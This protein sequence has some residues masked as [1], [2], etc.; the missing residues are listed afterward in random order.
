[1]LTQDDNELLTKTGP[2]TP[3]GELFRRFWLPAALSEELPSPDGPP[4]RVE[5]LG[6]KLVAFRD[7]DGNV[8]LIDAYCPH[9]GAPLFFGRNEECGLRCVY[10]GW[11][12]DVSGQCVDMPNAPEGQTFANKMAALTYPCVEAG[13]IVFTYMGP[14]VQQ[15]PFPEFEWRDLPEENRYVSKFKLECNYL[16]AMEG[17]FDPG[18]SPFLHTVIDG[19]WVPNP[20]YPG[21]RGPSQGNGIA[22]RPTPADEPFPRVV[23]PRR[24]TEEDRESWGTI[25]QSDS[26]SFFITSKQGADGKVSANVMPWMMPIFTTAGRSGPGTHSC[27]MRVPINDECMLFYRLRWSYEALPPLD[28]EEYKHGGFYYPA[29]I[30]GTWQTVD[31]VTNDY[32]IDRLTQKYFNYTGITP[33]PLQDIAMMEDQWG[34]I[35]DRTKEHLNTSDFRIIHIRR[36]LL[37]TVRNLN[38]GSEPSEPWHPEAYGYT[39]ET[40][41]KDSGSVDAVIEEAKA[42][43]KA[44][45]V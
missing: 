17:D 6:E 14:P 18:H 33:F 1:M 28:I 13:G 38:E 27:N 26:G 32:N 21:G 5:I 41:V 3:M 12:F 40:A 43:V 9:R 30:P 29:L 22:D 8:G 2:G 35:A 34:P 31:N 25:E 37:T 42:K 10:H 4:V 11:K 20:L 39:S 19:A 24:Q 15:P 36:R 44:S 16:Q 23:G 45:R 7:T